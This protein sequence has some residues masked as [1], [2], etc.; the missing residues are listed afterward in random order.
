VNSY[1]DTSFLLS[2]HGHDTNFFRAL[3]RLPETGIAWT[4]WNAVEFNNA[5]R[6]LVFR[7]IVAARH[8]PVMGT[9]IR[10]ALAC[11]DLRS[12]SLDASALWEETARLSDAHTIRLGA[13][14]LD[15]L[16]VAAARVLDCRYF[17]TFDRRQHE[18]ARAAGLICEAAPS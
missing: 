4:P 18:L 13:R 8:L 6:S 1:A 3:A 17:L 9:S 11:G 15:V 5:A 10:A 7:K 12:T 16:H 14:T 2:W